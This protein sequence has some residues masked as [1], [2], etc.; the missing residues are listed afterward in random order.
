VRHALSK[1]GDVFF[2][3]Y[4][5]SYLDIEIPPVWQS[6]NAAHLP[7]LM[8]VLHNRDQWEPSNVVFDGKHVRRHDKSAKEQPGTEWIDYGLSVFSR[9]L[10]ASWPSDDPFDLSSMTATLAQQGR[11]AGHE[12]ARRFYEIGKPE[13]LAETESYLT[14]LRKVQEN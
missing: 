9:E 4:G 6:F 1:L 5:D 2:V 10:L 12:V 13:G 7:A 3:L 14:G 8:T 11:L